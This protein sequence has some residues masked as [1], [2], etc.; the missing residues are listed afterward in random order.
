GK[1]FSAGREF[2]LHGLRGR[3]LAVEENGDRIVEFERPPDLATIGQTPL[4][5][6]VERAVSATDRDRY[7]TVYA[8]EEGAV[9][10]PTAGLHFTREMLA[11]LPH[12]FVTLHV[13]P[14][15][16]RPV[17]A[18][19]ITDH[20]MHR[21]P[22]FVSSKA[23]EAINGAQSVLAVGT[24]SVRVLET[25]AS[26]YGE[27]RSGPGET[28]L[29]IHPPYRFRRVD[30]LLTNFHL[31]QS[32]LLMLVAAFAGRE[33]ILEAYREAVR[34]RYRFFSYGDAMLIL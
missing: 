3:I 21:E 31:P 15:T 14:G 22:F 29:F 28:N 25:L 1:W 30:K 12:A 34:E 17:K 24:T 18:E 8:T 4:P 6:Y 23:A 20:V 26:R 33:L 19:T 32:T 5:P 27:V 16:F 10:A 2:I 9:A 11:R 13:G 7:Q